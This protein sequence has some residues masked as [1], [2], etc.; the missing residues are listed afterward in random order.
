MTI[1]VA[2]LMATYLIAC[3]GEGSSPGEDQSPSTDASKEVAVADAHGLNSDARTAPE[4]D[5]AFL[6][7]TGLDTPPSHPRDA[8]V[9]ASPDQAIDASPDQAI[10]ASPDQTID[11]SPDQAIDARPD[12]PIDATADQ[13]IDATPDAQV[14]AAP[15][16]D[17]D[18]DRTPD[19]QDNCPLH[20]N[21]D[22][23]DTDED[24]RGD[25]CDPCPNDPE[26]DLDGD[27][28]CGDVDLCPEDFDPAQDDLDEDDLG[29]ACDLDDDGDGILD[30][31]DLCPRVAG[32]RQI[33]TDGDG[34]GDDCEDDRDGDGILDAS[35]TCPDHPDVDQTDTDEDGVGDACDP[36]PLSDPDDL[37]EDQVCDDV[38]NCPGLANDQLDGDRDGLG[39]ACDPCPQDA[40]L[41]DPDE[42][43]RCGLRDNCPNEDNPGQEDTDGDSLG[44]ACDPCPDDHAND[45]D[46]DG[47]CE[48]LDVC[49]REH[50]DQ[51]DTDQDGLGD[52][53][54]PCPL[55]ADD[56]DGDGVCDAVDNCPGEDNPDQRDEDGDGVGDP[57]DPCDDRIGDADEDEVCDN[58]DNCLGVPNPDQADADEDG[59]G[60]LCDECPGDVDEDADGDGVCGDLDTCPD[61]YDPDQGNVDEDELGDYCDPDRDGDEVPDVVDN[62]PHVPNADQ[63]DVD[64]NGAGDAC[65]RV[66]FHDGFDDLDGWE[67]LEGGWGIIEAGQRGTA[68]ADSPEGSALN[69]TTV[70][71]R[72]RDTIDLSEAPRPRL[73]M[74]VRHGFFNGWTLFVDI[75]R[76]GEEPIALPFVDS[77][78][79]LSEGYRWLHVDL[80]EIAGSPEV[81]LTLRLVSGNG[82]RIGVD[83]DDLAI[84][85]AATYAPSP[86]PYIEDFEQGLRRVRLEGKT[87]LVE[88]GAL[89]PGHRLDF[90]PVN[91]AP[92][93]TMHSAT[94]LRDLDLR[95]TGRPRIRFFLSGVLT[96]SVT[97]RAVVS[98]PDLPTAR[99]TLLTQ[100]HVWDR[101]FRPYEASLLEFAGHTG[102]RVRVEVEHTYG[103]VGPIR[104]DD[105]EVFDVLQR[106]R[107]GPGFHEDFEQGFARWENLGW[108]RHEV[109]SP[110]GEFEATDSPDG[111]SA[112][113]R[114]HHLALPSPIALRETLAPSLSFQLHWRI[115]GGLQGQRFRLYL[116][117]SNGAQEVLL[118]MP[119]DRQ[120][121]ARRL[122]VD[123]RA[124][125]GEPALRIRF[126]LD[127]DRDVGD[128]VWLDDVR[129]EDHQSEPLSLPYREDF[130]GPLPDWRL[131]H[132]FAITDEQA[133]D[134]EA[135]LHESPG[136]LF[137]WSTQGAALARAIDLRGAE[138]P[139]LRFWTRYA[140]AAFRLFVRAGDEEVEVFAAVNARQS[141]WRRFEV[142]LTPYADQLI[143][144]RFESSARHGTDGAYIDGLE[145]LEPE[146]PEPIAA[147]FRED[148]EAPLEG[149]HLEGLWGRGIEFAHSG[150][151]S[152]S[153]SPAAGAPAWS[154]TS[155]WLERSFDL[156]ALQSPEL[157]FWTHYR[158]ADQQLLL[159]YLEIEGL[160]TEVIEVHGRG[161]QEEWVQQVIDLSPWRDR[162]VRVG[163]VYVSRTFSSPTGVDLDDLEVGE[164]PAP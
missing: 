149:W 90:A 20:P 79:H 102:V 16:I 80:P 55:D 3:D 38:D 106:P 76:P 95:N 138:R 164:A 67:A 4:P 101:G 159:L 151:T 87:A 6:R 51:T 158:I 35:D 96:G 47:V 118:P 30:R 103:D 133:R 81:R 91:P 112:R 1:R 26:D 123:L 78:R 71:L 40:D 161:L 125:I 70:R 113:Y 37:D 48:S 122:E 130:E 115:N 32:A 98:A 25:A 65:G 27:G 82:A 116:T 34:V 75:E 33:D 17:T 23:E 131:D 44:D 2:L 108:R 105:I 9:D 150:F 93:Q 69:N 114:V 74:W 83:I 126:E 121:L 84:T 104:I 117:Q 134:G 66:Y 62:C 24:T 31:V 64:G 10:D 120:D 52:A 94:L 139:V 45:A 154:V 77:S 61:I 85:D 43:G 28:H 128:G 29:D 152:L 99:L 13:T 136:G 147:P 135:S 163:F 145:V 18:E 137:E 146:V 59:D 8:S 86:L 41:E 46:R 58:V 89:S 124:Y 57:C 109:Q 155:A 119:T 42:D 22:Q 39:D 141:L 100:T 36:C 60:D 162:L 21:P 19:S 111:P 107:V 54:D 73:S 63:T 160:P 140:T 88:A 110:R 68:L 12:Q 53:C 56:P 5:V 14:D 127:S 7:D 144:I 153:D 97:V 15:P 148:F 156:S 157:R 129:V 49:P 11:A 50:D 92:A 132:P 142:D 143:W 72:L